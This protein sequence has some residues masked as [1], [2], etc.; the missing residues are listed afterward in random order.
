MKKL[1]FITL[2]LISP[3]T[4]NA[5]KC[6]VLD[7]KIGDNVTAEDVDA[8]SYEFRSSFTPSCYTVEDYLRLKRTMKDLNYDPTTMRKDQIRKLGRDMVAVVV[9]YGTLEKFM[10]EYS[11]D[12]LVM[13]VSTGTT[14][15][16]ES[17][18]FQQSEY[19][20]HPRTASKAIATK[21]CNTPTQQSNNRYSLVTRNTTEKKTIPGYTDLGLPS[22]TLWKNGNEQ[23]YYT[24]DEAVDKFGNQL[25]TREQLVE[26]IDKCTWK[27]TGSGYKV[28][29]PNG[30]SIYLPA[31]GERVGTTVVGEGGEGRYW[32][33]TYGGEIYAYYIGFTFCENNLDVYYTNRS[34]SMSV[35]LVKN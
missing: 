18:T 3:L 29:G 33:S 31:T 17:S 35:R 11:L 4:L 23:D 5:Q 30:N 9:V 32:S 21:L 34:N 22:E 27:K 26:L 24:Y 28:T 6:I 14:I 10:N 7:F 25:P 20:S 16:H 2:I 8:I 15:I 13:D 1:L 12:V 19:H